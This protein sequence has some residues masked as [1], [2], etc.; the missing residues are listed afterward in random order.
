MQRNVR[1]VALLDG[2]IGQDKQQPVE[3]AT[4]RQSS[5]D[6]CLFDIQ[7]SGNA[8]PGPGYKDKDNPVGIF[9]GKE[10][11]SVAGTLNTN[12]FSLTSEGELSSDIWLLS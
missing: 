3:L 9:D 6:S 7:L 12:Q 2:F 8:K 5:A 4:L 11:V 10:R 1:R